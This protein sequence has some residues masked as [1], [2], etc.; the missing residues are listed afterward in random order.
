ML[1]VIAKLVDFD[2]RRFDT[3]QIIEDFHHKFSNSWVIID[4]EFQRVNNLYQDDDDAF[5]LKTTDLD[6]DNQYLKVDRIREIKKHM[7]K[8]G[9]YKSEYGLL[10]L[11]RVPARQWLKSYAEG[12]NY[13]ITPLSGVN[14]NTKNTVLNDESEYHP[15]TMLDAYHRV[16]LHWKQVGHLVPRE[17]TIY[18]DS[19][20]FTKEIQELWPQYR[21]TSDAKPQPARRDEELITDF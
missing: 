6:G 7:P 19:D 4:G 21:I 2:P 11:H 13:R 8:T 17:H 1:D 3:G 16:W 10:Y 14:P 5:I 12:K 15:E 18:L 9:L 20:K